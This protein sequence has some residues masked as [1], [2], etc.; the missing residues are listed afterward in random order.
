MKKI[1]FSLLCALFIACTVNAQDDYPVFSVGAN[2][3][4]D[5]NTNAFRLTSDENASF[6]GEPNQFNIGID[7]GV[8]MTKK[9]RPRLE[10]RYVNM[11]YHMNWNSTDYPDFDKTDCNINYFDLNLHL[12]Y[13][14]FTVNKLEV[15]V[16]PAIKWEQK[17]GDFVKTY[18]N[19][20]SA[21]MTG[22]FTA[23][24][25]EYP[26][27][28]A[29]GAA[30]MIFKYNFNKHLGLTLTPEY[31]YFFRDFVKSNNKSYQRFN[32]NAGFEFTF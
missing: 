4:W 8:R 7:F 24:K 2:A 19:D 23:I 20:G 11:A 31:T 12:D 13:S 16:S 21:P 17:S 28:I 14:L 30:S 5:H 27:N 18:K 26:G 29:G 32:V 25:K 9:F 15:F 10:L 3:G 6:T 1:V 22:R